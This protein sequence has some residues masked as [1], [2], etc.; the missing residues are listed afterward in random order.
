MCCVFVITKAVFAASTCATG[1]S[2]LD[3]EKHIDT[4]YKT[5]DESTFMKPEGGLCKIAGYV[6]LEIPDDVYPIYNGFIMGSEV[7]LCNNGFLV[8]NGSCSTYAAGE[9][10]ED[11]EDLSLNANTM[12]TLT[13]GSCASGYQTYILNQQCDENTT[14]A[15]CGILCSSGLSYTDIGTCAQICQAGHTTL[16]TGTGLIYP[17]YATK[18]ITPSIN[19]GIGNSV[20]YVNLV[21]G[22]AE[23]ALHIKYNNQTYHAVQ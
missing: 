19:L 1:Y 18:Q 13:N 15:I 2:T 14:D 17:M 21:P 10:P 11:Y 22:S 9:C 12:A 23:G 3:V 7:T 6:L 4:T 16:R 20:C 8:N 5:F